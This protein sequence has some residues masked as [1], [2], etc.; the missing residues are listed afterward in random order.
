[1]FKKKKKKDFIGTQ[2]VRKQLKP[3][4]SCSMLTL[5]HKI[6]SAGAGGSAQRLGASTALAEDLSSQHLSPRAHNCL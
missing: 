3:L 4:F 2:V 1:M 5:A 6:T